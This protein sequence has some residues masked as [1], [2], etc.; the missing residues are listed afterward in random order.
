[1]ADQAVIVD[2]RATVAV[3]LAGDSAS[4][5]GRKGT[6]HA[7]IHHRE[8][9]Y[10]W[11]AG[12][13]TQFGQWFQNIAIG[14]LALTLTDSPSF[15]GQVAFASGVPI[16]LLS[17]PAGALLD[18][19]DR[20][21]ALLA[22]QILGALLAL[23]IAFINW[24]GWIEP[25][26]LIVAAV[27]SG[28]LLAVVQ[29]ATQSLAPALVPREDLPNALAL[30]SAGSSSTRIIGPSLGGVLI[31][32]LGIAGCY[33]AQAITFV[34]AA[35]LTAAVTVPRNARP[36]VTIGGGVLDGLRI[37]RRDPTLTGLLL[38]A[39]VPALLAYPYIQLLPVFARDVLHLGPRGLGI[40]MSTSGI[41][42]FVG[43]LIVAR[44]GS[45]PHKGR[46]TLIMGISYGFVLSAFALSPWPA[47]S[48][49]I[50]IFSGFI[51]S[52]FYS[53]NQI[54][55][56]LATSE[57]MRGRVMGALAVSFGLQPVGALFIGALAQ[58]IG[59]PLAVTAGSMVSTLC[60]ILIAARY[61]TLWR[62]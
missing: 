16:L 39:S 28:I 44:L 46:L 5:A 45:W 20:R 14:W 53:T 32:L 8:F 21:R 1:M 34:V 35:A 19:I 48:A 15:V 38:L 11:T 40:I 10:L 2:E 22:A 23:T 25:W 42:A 49:I 4:A 12:V 6:F 52:V 27:L 33:L 18:R 58:Q 54:L 7:V 37:I 3:A 57:E 30:N 24:R 13:V 50:L 41:G 55:V 36:G 62:L 51:G 59:A 17:F 26:H 43:A 47:V 61:R 60:T 56:Q 9:R 29:P 31:G